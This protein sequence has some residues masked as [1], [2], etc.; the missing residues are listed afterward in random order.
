MSI[1]AGQGNKKLNCWDYFDC[2]REISNKARKDSVCNVS[3]IS[4]Q[5]GINGGECAGRHCWTIDGS[6]CMTSFANKIGGMEVGTVRHKEEHCA[7]CNFR[8][9]VRD[10][11]GASYTD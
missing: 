10:E 7:K 2:G 6:Y 1:N 5:N 3:I 8:K 4:S 9:L 11:E